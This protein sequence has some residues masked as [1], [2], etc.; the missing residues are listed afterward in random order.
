MPNKIPKI[1]NC[2]RCPEGTSFDTI[3]ELR[4]HQWAV[5]VES[6][7]NLR[8]AARKTNSDS[9][10]FSKTKRY[11]CSQCSHISVGAKAMLKHSWK[12]RHED[13]NELVPTVR[14]LK[15]NGSASQVNMPGGFKDMPVSELLQKMLD[16]RNFLDQMASYI[17]GLTTK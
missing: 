15:T 11:H 7:K 4:K 16:Q 5:L 3:S 6:F 2:K 14:E 17:K 10:R 9:R 8:K 1:L 13:S 12:H